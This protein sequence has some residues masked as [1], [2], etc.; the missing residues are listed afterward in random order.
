MNHDA[1]GVRVGGE[2]LQ[3]GMTWKEQDGS[4]TGSSVLKSPAVASFNLGKQPKLKQVLITLH[5]IILP[6]HQL[7]AIN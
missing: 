5:L 2:E 1:P 3:K 4:E 7:E 6:Y